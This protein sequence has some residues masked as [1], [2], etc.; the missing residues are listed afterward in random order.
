[1]PH[2]KPNWKIMLPGLILA[3][4]SLACGRSA[5]PVIQP[6]FTTPE[7]CQKLDLDLPFQED[8]S[9]LSTSQYTATLFVDGKKTDQQVEIS[10]RLTCV[11]E[12][13]YQSEE[14][15]GT[16]RAYL[17]IYTV[18]EQGQASALFNHYSQ[19]L[20]SSPDYCREDHD[21]SVAVESFGPE[22]TYYVEKNVYGSREG[23]PL[24][25]YHSASLV[26]LIAG[27]G[28]YHILS[29]DVT[30]PE[31]APESDFVTDIVAEIESSLIPQ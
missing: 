19:E 6:G 8:S 10:D 14:K 18:K 27:S 11:W 23:D 26:R 1:M 15:V 7:Q 12:D 3:L 5:S 28:E 31:L 13:S 22:R 9:Y 2:L 16:I 24:P 25:S 30:H 17:E 4:V 20:S 21:C 29:L